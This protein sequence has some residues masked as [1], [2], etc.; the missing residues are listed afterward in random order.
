MAWRNF[1]LM[2]SVVQRGTPDLEYDKFVS[3]L[4]NALSALL[5][6]RSVLRLRPITSLI[7][8][9]IVWGFLYYLLVNLVDI[10][11]GFSRQPILAGASFFSGFYRL[12]AD[13]MT[14]LILVSI[15]YFFVRRFLVNPKAIH[16]S[17]N[18]IL[19]SDVKQKIRRDSLIVYIFIILHV[20]FRLIGASAC[21]AH[22]TLDTW[23]PLASLVSL[24]MFDIDQQ[25]LII[26]ERCSWW[27]SIV[28][29]II[30]VPY[31]PYS[32]HIHLLAGPIN[33]FLKP[34]RVSLGA[35]SEIDFEDN[36]VDEFGVQ[37]LEQLGQSQILDAFACIMCNRCQDVCPAY[38]TGKE[39]SP[40]ALE[41]NKRTLINTQMLSLANGDSSAQL[42]G[43]II[44]ESA[45]WACTTCGACVDICPVGN[46]PMIDIMELRRY[47]VLTEG[48]FPNSLQTAFNGMERQSNP[49]NVQND[50]FSWCEGL[51]V[52]T[53]VDN[54]DFEYLYWVGC[55]PKYDPVAKKVARAFIKIL[56]T[57]KVNYA[58]LGDNECCTGDSAR[59]SGNEYLFNEMANH[60]VAELNNINVKKIL[61]TCPHCLHSISA[62]YC[63]FGGDF[64]VIHHT[65][66]INELINKGS[67]V[68]D[69]N[70][71]GQ[72]N[73]TFHDPC[74]LGR[75]NGIFDDPRQL[76]QKGG[77]KLLEMDNNRRN[78]FCCG[79]GGGQM[80][81]EEES[82]D[83]S[84]SNMR[85]TEAKKSG[86]DVLAVAC[87]FCSV[88]LNDAN[89]S[90]GNTMIIKDVAEI[91]ADSIDMKGL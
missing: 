78:S 69:S 12:I 79:A 21:I 45:L 63:K 36:N 54:P 3:R 29:I 62:E 15:V 44:S 10:V 1:R 84:V 65:T 61:V 71:M 42:L 8:T 82:G 20:G 66:L 70:K 34:H 46:E 59:R 60:N 57:A 31:F 47:Q 23:Q 27:I 24:S 9:L 7:H 85:F 75:H 91:I 58:V 39:L 88:M 83:T 64:E 52:P 4:W 89:Q 90:D 13:I 19:Q 68:V 2:I 17:P 72:S 73:I 74:Y 49:W 14:G 80:W 33:I 41:I 35:L 87:P 86:A 37:R 26:I 5:T 22:S 67:I 56:N 11:N 16:F 6:Q 40:A 38:V 53:V 77:G 32:K 48:E 43:S 18:V 28:S 50:P 30:F 55:A 51:D 76:I 81:K 25:S